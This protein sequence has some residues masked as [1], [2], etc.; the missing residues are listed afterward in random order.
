MEIIRKRISDMNHAAYN[1]RVQ[2]QKGDDEYESLK[3]SI[4]QYGPVVPII[5]N[6]QTNNIVGGHQRLTVL[7]DMGETETD[8]SVVDLPLLEEKELNIVLNKSGGK[9]DDEKLTGLIV[10]LGDRAIETGF[11]EGEIDALQNKLDQMLDKPFLVNEQ[12]NIESTFNL[13]LHFDI[14]YRDEIN[15]YIKENGKDGLVDLIISTAK[16]E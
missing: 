16:G 14:T 1:P 9:W 3:H 13:T 10:K 12:E 7:Q 4:Q 5:W 8:V 15:D 11:T 2:L 6:K